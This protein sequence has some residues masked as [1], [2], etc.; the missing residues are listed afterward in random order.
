MKQFGATR[1]QEVSVVCRLL[2]ARQRI[3]DYGDARPCYDASRDRSWVEVHK[4]PVR[5]QLRDKTQVRSQVSR[6]PSGRCLWLRLRLVYSGP[7]FVPWC[8]VPYRKTQAAIAP[9]HQSPSVRF[10]TFVQASGIVPKNIS[11]MPSQRPFVRRKRRTASAISRANCAHH[12]ILARLH[13]SSTRHQDGR[14]RVQSRSLCMLYCCFRILIQHVGYWAV[15]IATSTRTW[16]ATCWMVRR[17]S[18]YGD[19]VRHLDSS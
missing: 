19:G 8:Q 4:V 6:F 15:E 12:D 1:R 11:E 9:S 17:A 14:Q 18:C 5:D 2:L 10:Q 13:T 3:S 16:A 7:P